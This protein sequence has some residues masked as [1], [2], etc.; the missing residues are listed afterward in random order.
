MFNIKQIVVAIFVLSAVGCFFSS[1]P[2]DKS[3]EEKFRSNEAAFNR[4]VVMIRE[5]MNLEAVDL[6]AAYLPS[7]ETGDVRPKANIPAKRTDEYHRLLKQT[8][9]NEIRNIGSGII[10]S[11]WESGTIDPMNSGYKSYLY[12]ETLP[13][14]LLTSLDDTS[15]LPSRRGEDLGYK[16]IADNWYLE[17]RY[18]H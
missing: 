11:V 1:P 9:I 4:L 12:T 15:E 2:S 14:P 8:G 7:K 18:I 3:M 5:D 6:E 17:F 13:S 10:F 16:K